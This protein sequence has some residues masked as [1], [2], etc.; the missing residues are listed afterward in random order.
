MHLSGSVRAI[1]SA[2]PRV[3][4]NPFVFAGKAGK[5]IAAFSSPRRRS[6]TLCRKRDA[7]SLTGVS[8]IFDAPE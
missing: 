3:N 6:I 4:G 5:P 2:L 1:I 8:M 7:S